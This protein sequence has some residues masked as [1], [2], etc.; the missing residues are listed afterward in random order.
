LGIGG[1]KRFLVIAIAGLCVLPLVPERAWD[2]FAG[3]K[4]LSSTETVALADPEG[5]AAQRLEIQ[6]TALAILGDSPIAGTGLG[7]YKLANALYAPDLG[8]RDTH[9]TYLNIAAETGLIGLALWMSMLILVVRRVVCEPDFARDGPGRWLL[10][11]LFAFLVAGFF[12]T[13]AAVSLPYL[14]LAIAWAWAG[15]SSDA[16]SGNATVPSR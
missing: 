15:V 7:T 12:G 14:V 6:R 2:R 13:Y 8:H 1:G 5:S 10:R 11:G 3:M 9:N 16:A 4:N